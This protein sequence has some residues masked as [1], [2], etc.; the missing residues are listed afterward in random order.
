MGG[1]GLNKRRIEG[2]TVNGGFPRAVAWRKRGRG[3][4][5]KDAS[6]SSSKEPHLHPCVSGF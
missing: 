2:P 1:K 5:G 4:G 6:G 3:T